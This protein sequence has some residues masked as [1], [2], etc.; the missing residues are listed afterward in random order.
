MTLLKPRRLTNVLVANWSHH[1]PNVCVNWVLPNF[2]LK[3]HMGHKVPC[4]EDCKKGFVGYTL[5]VKSE[6]SLYV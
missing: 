1:N 5:S 2:G 3:L 4:V 6:I